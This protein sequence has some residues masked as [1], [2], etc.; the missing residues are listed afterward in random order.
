MGLDE[1]RNE[2]I[3]SIYTHMYKWVENNFDFA[4]F[5]YDGVD[6]SHL[7]NV[8]GNARYFQFVLKN[9][10]SFYASSLLFSD[11]DSRSLF[12]QL[13]KYRCLGH[14]HMRIQE[15]M[16]WS[17][18]KASLDRASSYVSRP[19]NVDFVGLF[20]PLQHHENLPG[21]NGISLTVDAWSLNVAFDLGTNGRRQYYFRRGDVAIK[22][23]LGDWVIDGGA[24]F[25]DTAVF[26]SSTIGK[27][28]KVFAFEPLPIHVNVIDLNIRQ[29]NLLNRVEVVPAGIGEVTNGI[30]RIDERLRNVTSP[31]FSLLGREGQVPTISIDDFAH[32][33]ELKKLDFIKLDIEGFELQALKGAEKIIDRYRPKLA[34]SLY[35]KPSDFFDIPIFLKAKFPFYQLYLD[36]Y[37]IFSEET[38]L[39]AI[40][41]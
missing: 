22:P 31:G 16:T 24:C 7:V 36:H 18:V 5:G 28:G 41:H 29:N 11:T 17:T 19:S 38:V 6:R 40:A 13:V 35:H 4:R 12:W 14:P 15:S 30:N 2:L 21:D 1:I 9:L 23:E 8:I 32:R 10:D 20:G 34:I 33:K 39:Y 25:G 26:I 3:E 37:T 27:D